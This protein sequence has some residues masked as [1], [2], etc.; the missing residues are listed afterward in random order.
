ME[1]LF[2]GN[3]DLEKLLFARKLGFG[4]L[5]RRRKES[6]F[7]GSSRAYPT[8]MGRIIT[9][10]LMTHLRGKEKPTGF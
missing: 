2:K 4:A 8:R 7:T 9:Q 10:V 3:H 5:T 1:Q 6:K